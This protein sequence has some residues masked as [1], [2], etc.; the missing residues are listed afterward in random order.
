MRTMTSKVRMQAA[1]SGLPV[2][3]PPVAPLYLDLYLEA[4]ARQRAAESYLQLLGDRSECAL[5]PDQELDIQAHAV[6]GAF[7]ALGARPDWLCWM[8]QLQPAAWLAECSLRREGRA[9][10]R[11]HGPS[12][13]RERLNPPQAENAY[14]SDLWN[15]P[16][17]T[18]PAEVDQIIPSIAAQEILASGR[19]A[20]LS[21]LLEDLGHETFVAA[22][23]GS[24]FSECYALLGFQGLML[25]PFD[26]PE[27]FHYLMRRMEAS[28]AARAQA[29]TRLG[30][31]GVFIEESFTSAD[32]ISPG[33]YD[34]FVFPYEIGLV[35][36]LRS[37]GT[38][39]IFYITGDVLPRLERLI[40][41]QPT[42]LAVEE[43]KKGFHI[44]LGGIAD[45]V[46]QR[47]ALFGNLDATRVKDW[48]DLELKQ[49]LE[50][51]LAA[52]GPARGFVFSTG[53][54]LPLDTPRRRV[55]A[56]IRIAQ[57]VGAA[58]ILR[59]V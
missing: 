3:R 35:R 22:G 21:R 25:M 5:Q 40:A 10:W 27:L 49:E 7:A 54:P 52:A 36:Q 59:S 39:V 17:P 15:R 55:Q 1:L 53:S 47:F 14:G 11:V 44:D 32:L 50:A 38:P 58:S 2:D 51:Q 8:P 23:M 43:S 13:V 6:E 42:A 9:L 33:L 24:P 4:E 34:E 20:L 26:H 31:H 45:A 12:G 16:L 57:A 18:S 37:S 30:V 48:T 56:F 29:F 19:L 46:G 41:L 28:L